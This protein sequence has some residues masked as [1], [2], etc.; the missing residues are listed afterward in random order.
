[1]TVDLFIKKIPLVVKEL[2]S[3]EASDHRRSINQEAIALLEEALALRAG[4]AE[5]RRS[6]LQPLLQAY[7]NSPSPSRRHGFEAMPLPGSSPAPANRP[8]AT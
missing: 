4:A 5:W 8:I 2:I 6:E 7:S 3:R 1:M